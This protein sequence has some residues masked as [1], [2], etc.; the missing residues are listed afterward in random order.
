VFISWA[1]DVK[2]KHLRLFTK[3]VI[4]G[5]MYWDGTVSISSV[6]NKRLHEILD[7]DPVITPIIFFSNRNTFPINEFPH[8][9]IPYS[10]TEWK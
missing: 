9:I 3:K 1:E 5:N 10:M 8:N 2:V 7:V 6:L 4:K